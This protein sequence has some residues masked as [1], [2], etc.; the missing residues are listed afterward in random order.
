MRPPVN[1]DDFSGAWRCPRPVAL[2]EPRPAKLRGIQVR[3]EGKKFGGLRRA[4]VWGSPGEHCSSG[5]GLAPERS[6]QSPR[7][8]EGALPCTTSA[9]LKSGGAAR[10]G[11]DACGRAGSAPYSLRGRRVRAE[12]GLRGSG[13]GPARGNSVLGLGTARLRLLPYRRLRARRPPR[14]QG[15]GQGG[16][17]APRA[18]AGRGAAAKAATL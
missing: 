15:P 9:R 14:P 11:R 18:G 10:G 5:A 6:G 8:R 13:P 4:A 1:V 12:S 7:G 16:G 3:R 17:W 2:A